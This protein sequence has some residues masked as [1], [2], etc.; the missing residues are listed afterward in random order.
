MKH[1]K[2]S[3]VSIKVAHKGGRAKV[4]KLPLRIAGTTYW[5]I[6]SQK[7]IGPKPKWVMF[8]PDSP[9]ELNAGEVVELCL[10]SK[11]RRR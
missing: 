10:D 9:I 2:I 5:L 6:P 4:P 7:T 1:E 11:P 3:Y 8:T